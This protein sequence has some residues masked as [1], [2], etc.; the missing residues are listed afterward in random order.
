MIKLSFGIAQQAH[1]DDLIFQLCFGICY[2]FQCFQTMSISDPDSAGKLSPFFHRLW[3]YLTPR[4]RGAVQLV[5]R[6]WRQ[7]LE[8]RGLRRELR[9][10]PDKAATAGLMLPMQRL[11]NLTRVTLQPRRRE[12]VSHWKSKIEDWSESEIT[13]VLEV[14]L[15]QDNLAVLDMVTANIWNMILSEEM[16]RKLVVKMKTLHCCPNPFQLNTMFEALR[17]DENAELE[18]LTVTLH[19]NMRYKGRKFNHEFLS[20]TLLVSCVHH[21]SSLRLEDISL[22]VQKLNILLSSIANNQ[23]IKL[24]KLYLVNMFV[25]DEENNKN[26]EDQT[27]EIV[28]DSLFS[29][30][31]CNLSS[32]GI[33]MVLD[34]CGP[35]E[36][37]SL[38]TEQLINI[39]LKLA[40]RTQK[41][42]ELEIAQS[43]DFY[44][45]PADIFAEGAASLES[46]SL[47][48]CCVT[49]EQIN[50]LMKKSG[51]WNLKCLKLATSYDGFHPCSFSE[52]QVEGCL[53]LQKCELKNPHITN[54][55]VQTLFHLVDETEHCW[56]EELRLGICLDAVREGKVYICVEDFEEP[57]EDRT[58]RPPVI[59]PTS[60]VHRV[61]KKLS[62]CDIS[63]DFYNCMMNDK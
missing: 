51:K 55:Q 31:V 9:I 53:K 8:Q 39:F 14:I 54:Q 4:D 52:I 26:M 56:L 34:S 28:P 59:L 12:R 60:L 43:E 23:E 50:A 21:L 15:L 19:R 44:Q 5:C 42:T 57:W 46:L 18:H 3:Q 38:N 6:V 45:I 40:E 36:W 13:Q 2:S 58:R 49:S 32:F 27:S 61:M 25:Y 1:C 7:Q 11:Q 35:E 47:Q 22:P 29:S 17:T 63:S 10:S 30:A 33:E 24:R 37:L 48:N 62:L 20:P 41:L 16:I